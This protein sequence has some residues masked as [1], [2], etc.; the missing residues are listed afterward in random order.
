MRINFDRLSKLAGLPNSGG[1]RSLNESAKYESDIDSLE[2]EASELE[3][4]ANEN[5]DD[6]EE[7]DPTD[8]NQ[9]IEVDET[10]LVQELRRMKNL[11]NESKRR[12]RLEESRRRQRKQALYEAQLKRVIDQ[13]VKNVIDEMNYNSG[14]V[15]GN[16]RPTRSR[17]GYSHQGSYISGPGFRR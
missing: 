2:N 11:M 4:L 7:E 13:E 3:D 12:K 15:Y 6:I 14:W 16:N 17:H 1:R 5:V 9:M 8:E 10:V